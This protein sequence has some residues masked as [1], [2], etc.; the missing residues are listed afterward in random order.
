MSFPRRYPY[1]VHS[2]A[3]ALV[4]DYYQGQP[5]VWVER[6]GKM[7][8]GPY[9]YDEDRVKR[10]VE[11]YEEQSNGISNHKSSGDSQGVLGVSPTAR[12]QAD[13]GPQRQRQDVQ[14]GHAVRVRGLRG[15]AEQGRVDLAGAGPSDDVRLEALAFLIGPTCGLKPA[16]AKRK[17]ALAKGATVE[18]LVVCVL[19]G[20]K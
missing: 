14:D 8:A 17:L 12:P 1:T 13:R 11:L 3:L 16:E 2:V 9:A 20:G 7:A 15:Y 19:S 18:E 6:D 10:A 4:C 5:A